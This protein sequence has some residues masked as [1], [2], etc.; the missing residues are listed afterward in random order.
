MKL[1]KSVRLIFLVAAA[2]SVL[3]GCKTTGNSGKSEPWQTVG[4]A[5]FPI[6]VD[7]A[8]LNSDRRAAFEGTNIKR[9]RKPNIHY[10]GYRYRQRAPGRSLT[11]FYAPLQPCV[12]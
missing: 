9:D 7:L 2:A 8:K 5:G 12:G 10:T 6:K 3:A 1:L 11:Y 4:A